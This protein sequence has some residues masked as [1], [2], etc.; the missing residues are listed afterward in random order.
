[1]ISS[2]IQYAMPGYAPARRRDRLDG[3]VNFDEAEGLWLMN[4]NIFF[5]E[6]FVN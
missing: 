1:M 5:K 4:T 6:H 3:Q 2:P